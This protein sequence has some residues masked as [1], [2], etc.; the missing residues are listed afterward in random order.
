MDW[1]ARCAFAV[2]MYANKRQR[3]KAAKA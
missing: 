3:K 1:Q 2:L